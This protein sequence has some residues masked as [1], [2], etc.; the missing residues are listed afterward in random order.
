[1]IFPCDLLLWDMTG[2]ALPTSCGVNRGTFSWFYGESIFHPAPKF[3]YQKLPECLLNHHF[4]VYI[5]MKLT[6]LLK[7]NDNFMK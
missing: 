6:K 3:I 1:M 2:N 4:D 7:K 5:F